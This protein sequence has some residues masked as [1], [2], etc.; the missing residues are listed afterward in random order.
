MTTASAITI[1]HN[2]GKTYDPVPKPGLAVSRFC[3][4]KC[5][6]RHAQLHRADLYAA[7]P[8]ADEPLVLP[9]RSAPLEPEILLEPE[10]PLPV[11][12]Q[13]GKDYEPAPQKGLSSARFCSISC[14]VRAFRAH[15][16]PKPEPDQKGVTGSNTFPRPPDLSSGLCVTSP[17]AM[18]HLWT[19]KDP[20]D[21]AAAQRICTSCPVIV[22]CAIWALQLPNDG[23][24]YGGMSPAERRSKRRKTRNR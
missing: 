10:I 5:Q 21:R 24:V 13:C 2:C 11:C 20:A 23:C 19:S 14:Q 22:S 7:P 17:P 4:H 6:V 18:R 15:R 3:S 8:P 16:T 9:P 12:Q 1:C